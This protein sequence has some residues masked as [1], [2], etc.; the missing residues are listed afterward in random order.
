MIISLLIYVSDLRKASSVKEK[1]IAVLDFIL[2]PFTGLTA[3]FYFGALLM[4]YGL[5]V[6]TGVF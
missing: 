2:S 1:W 3:L 5:C 4:L 6:L